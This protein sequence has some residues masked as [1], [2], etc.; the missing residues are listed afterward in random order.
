MYMVGYTWCRLHFLVG[1][2]YL[3]FYP[4]SQFSNRTDFTILTPQWNSSKVLILNLPLTLWDSC[5]HKQMTTTLFFLQPSILFAMKFMTT[6][7]PP[8][9]KEKIHLMFFFAFMI[10]KSPPRFFLNKKTHL[11][12]KMDGCKNL[13]TKSNKIPQ[14]PT[15]SHKMDVSHKIHHQNKILKPGRLQLGP[16]KFKLGEAISF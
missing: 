5:H 1:N 16:I 2:Q 4:S 6:K 11:Q 7:S 10:N 14:N 8:R 15:K 12:F 3:R 9:L 13:P